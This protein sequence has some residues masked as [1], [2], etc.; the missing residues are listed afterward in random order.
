MLT[1]KPVAEIIP[2]KTLQSSQDST[3]SILKTLNLGRMLKAEVIQGG[4]ENALLQWGNFQFRAES[5]VLLEEGQKLNLLVTENSPQVK[6]KILGNNVQALRNHWPILT[7]KNL[8]PRLLEVLLTQPHLLAKPLKRESVKNLELFQNLQGEMANLDVE[9][10]GQLLR[11]LGMNCSKEAAGNTGL[12]ER[13]MLKSCLQ[14]VLAGLKEPDSDLGR[15][16]EAVLDG[17]QKNSLAGQEGKLS[18]AFFTWLP[19]PFLEKGFLVFQHTG[20]DGLS[21]E[22]SPWRLSL[23]LETE[24][25]GELRI[26]FLQ[27]EDGLLLKFIS[28]SSDVRGFL[29]SC[30]DELKDLLRAVPLRGLAF[31][32]AKE[33]PGNFLLKQI[34]GGGESI[35]ETWA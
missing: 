14:E 4:K 35:L 2:T 1:V 24:S 30:Q 10:V 23:F 11:M 33:P 20:G 3:K 18:E 12:S 19:L 9:R 17:L 29:E 26:D 25:L 7:E 22:E 15:K 21:A 28:E 34:V 13:E 16:L 32:T 27:E 8:L 5:K 6:L 31:E